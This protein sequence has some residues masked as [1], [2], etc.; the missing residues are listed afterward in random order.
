[1]QG[2]QLVGQL[3]SA[4]QKALAEIANSLGPAGSMLPANVPRSAAL[5]GEYADA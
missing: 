1:M 5:L 2:Y 3:S 4:L